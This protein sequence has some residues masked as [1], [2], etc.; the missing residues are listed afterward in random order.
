MSTYI[1]T[2][3][4]PGTHAFEELILHKKRQYLIRV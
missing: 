4:A 3:R 2:N 1:S